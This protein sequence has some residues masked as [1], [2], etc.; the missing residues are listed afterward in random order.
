MEKNIKTAGIRSASLFVAVAFVVQ[1][2]FVLL[3]TSEGLSYIY[4]LYAGLKSEKIE[5]DNSFAEY[6]DLKS[7]FADKN[8]F[9]IGAD[10]GVSKSYDVVLD[11]L[12]FVK[13]TFDVES[14]ILPV[15]TNTAKKINEIISAESDSYTSLISALESSGLYT[16]E[17]VNFVRDLYKLN[18]TL[19]PKRKL[20][21]EGYTVDS[22]SSV[23]VTKMTNI[24]LSK[25]NNSFSREL[26]DIISKTKT[27]DFF[28]YFDSMKEEYYEFLGDET[29]NE[30]VEVENHWRNGDYTEWKFVSKIEKYLESKVLILVPD[31]TVTSSLSEKL[32]ETES[33]WCAVKIMYSDCKTLSKNKEVVDR[34]DT[35]FPFVSSST[36]SFVSSKATEPFFERYER[37]VTEN[38]KTSIDET[39]CRNFFIVSSSDASSYKSAEEETNVAA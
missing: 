35:V 4:P 28:S 25:W 14:V 12:R 6:Y 22:V 2:I 32:D 19:S 8:V 31:S 21:V 7:E 38:D 34:E 5:E 15:G 13:K 33:K 9:L 16:V 20:T 37:I 27:E 10:V 26:Y 24:I 1:F 17:F 23:S 29:F 11:Y 36:F 18:G 30:F 39:V 3:F